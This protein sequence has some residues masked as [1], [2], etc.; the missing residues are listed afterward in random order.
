MGLRATKPEVSKTRFKALIYSE[1]GVGKTHLCC[2]FPSVYYIDSEKIKDYKHFIEL[3]RKNNGDLIYLTDISEIINEVK[4]LLSTKHQYKT[5]VIDSISFPYGLLANLEVDRLSAKSSN[6]E[7]T[8]FGANIAKPKRLI[9]HLGMLLSRLDMN[10]VVTAHER[11]KFSSNVEIGKTFDI[12]EKLSHALGTTINLR[13]QGS[14][15]KMFIEKSRY[16]E[17]KKGDVVDFKGYETFE[18]ALGKE[19]FN[20]ESIVE[21]LASPGQVSE[22]KRLV[23]LLSIPEETV[24]K[25][26]IKADSQSWE[27][28]NA[29]LI[30]K[31]IDTYKLK[32]QGEAA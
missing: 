14:V 12:S 1:P 21:A 19:M 7:G 10:V 2:S 15:K 25:I 9:F 3:I 18:N 13:Q 26:L 6:S 24:Q 4:S 23:Q 5:L 31:C 28:M 16:P 8:E 27:E 11:S 20:S 29:H 32:I 17:F 22:I 30:Q